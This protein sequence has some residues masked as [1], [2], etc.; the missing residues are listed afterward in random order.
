MALLETSL[1]IAGGL[2]LL[3]AFSVHPRMPAGYSATFAT[4]VG[5]ILF[6]VGAFVN[7]TCI[8][9]S[10]ARLGSG[11]W[12]YLATLVG[13]F[14]G[15]LIG[16]VLPAPGQLKDASRLLGSPMW[17]ALLVGAVL[18]ARS[19]SHVRRV[20]KNAGTLEPIWSPPVATIM[21]GR[22]A[23]CAWFVPIRPAERAPSRVARS[24][25]WGSFDTGGQYRADPGRRADA[26]ALRM[27][28]L[29]D[30]LPH[31]LC[32]SAPDLCPIGTAGEP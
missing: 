1:W 12:A 22:R 6:A 5:G 16:R 30:N 32:G 18:A 25:G 9:G 21:I 3:N 26:L 27:A 11:K 28:C 2:V 7:R 10:V 31:D 14:P 8:F 29:C 17:L 4:V 20:R 24:W 19:L 15:C 13:Y 23:R